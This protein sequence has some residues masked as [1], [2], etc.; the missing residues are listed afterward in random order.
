MRHMEN[1]TV[2]IIPNKSTIT[3]NVN[4]IESKGRDYQGVLKKWKP[5]LSVRNTLQIQR[6]TQFE[7]EKTKKNTPCKQYLF[8]KLSKKKIV[9]I[10]HKVLQKMN[11]NKHFPTPSL[12]PKTLQKKKKIFF[13]ENE[14]FY[15]PIS[16]MDKDVK[17]L[18]KISANQI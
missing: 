5:T 12:R 1:K 3:L 4:I 11:K 10:L 6:Q 13:K 2:D 16:L 8:F 7:S 14:K 17:I 18:N 15:R 9:T